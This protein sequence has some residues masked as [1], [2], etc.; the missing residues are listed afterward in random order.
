[1]C[2]IVKRKCLGMRIGVGGTVEGGKGVGKEGKLVV[3]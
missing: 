1:M 3:R 2:G